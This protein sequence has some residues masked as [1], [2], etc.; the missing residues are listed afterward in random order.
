MINNLSLN[1]LNNAQNA[2]FTTL[3]RLS[4]G[5][6]INSAKDDPAGL[7][8]AVAMASQLSGN[9][10]AMNNINDGLSLTDTQVV[11]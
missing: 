10:Q 8:I 6:R 4:S 3:Q 9:S 1:N 7:A 11:L 2:Q 5:S